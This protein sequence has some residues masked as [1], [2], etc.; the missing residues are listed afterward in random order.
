MTSFCEYSKPCPIITYTLED[1]DDK[2][3]NYKLR[4]VGFME[5]AAEKPEE[6]VLPDEFNGGVLAKKQ[7]VRLLGKERFKFTNNSKDEERIIV[8]NKSVNCARM[9]PSKIRSA[10]HS[11]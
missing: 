10:T 4:V 7:Q 3:Y 6:F 11:P 2:A 9:R 5:Q 8:R 1:R